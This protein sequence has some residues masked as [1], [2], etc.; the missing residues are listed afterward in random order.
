M[1]AGFRFVLFVAVLSMV[2]VA[3]ARRMEGQ[4]LRGVVRDSSSRLP[5]P[6]A[7]VS[8]LDSTATPVARTITNERGQFR[9]V[10]LGSTVRGLRVVRL[11]F[12][13]ARVRLP[14]P[15]D[16]VIQVEVVLASI[17]MALTPVQ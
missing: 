16:G 14:D 7:V 12:R 4:E 15:S 9:V 2:A 17:S 5:I 13:P 1:R 10:L 6:G 3:G 8:L 11:G